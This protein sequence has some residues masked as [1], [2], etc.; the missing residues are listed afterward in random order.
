[1]IPIESTRMQTF[2][3]RCGPSLVGPASPSSRPHGQE[4]I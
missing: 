4:V 3:T 2:D 1:M